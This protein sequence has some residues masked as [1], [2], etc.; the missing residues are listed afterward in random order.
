MAVMT[1]CV[2]DIGDNFG[3]RRQWQKT[4][5]SVGRKCARREKPRSRLSELI[6][7]GRHQ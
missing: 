3:S 2:D 7:R 6:E 4:F 5:Y 1:N